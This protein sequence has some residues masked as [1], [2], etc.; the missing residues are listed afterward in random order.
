MNHPL[1][2]AT[3]LRHL[4]RLVPAATLLALAACGGGAGGEN[5]SSAKGYVSVGG[6]V[7]GLS[8]SVVLRNNGGDDL[9][10]SGPGAFAFKLL[11][12]NGSTYAVTVASQPSGQFCTVGNGSGTASSDV[13]TVT[14][15][16]VSDV[17]IGGTVN[18]LTGTVALQ[19]NGANNLAT[20][21]N[22][23]FQ[24]STRIKAGQPYAVTVLTHP[25]NQTC[26]VTN[27]AGT[28]TANVTNVVIDCVTF[29]L[30]PLPTIYGT[31]KAIAYG[32][33]RAGGP[34]AG[35]VPTDAQITEDLLLMERAGFRLIRLFGADAVS[36]KIL[37]I[38]TASNPLLKFQQG[39]YLQGATL[40]TCSDPVNN[41]QIAK[42]IEL[43]RTY[44]NVVTVSVGNETSFANNLPVSCL[45]NYIR[46][47]RSKV[48]QPVTADDDYTFFAGRAANGS[49]PDSIVPLIDFVAIHMYPISNPNGWD[50]KQSGV[51]AGAAR[52]TAMMNAALDYS[53]ASYNAVRDYSYR[54]SSGSSVSIGNTRP[55]VVGETGW[56]AIRTNTASEI[57]GFAARETNAKWYFDLVRGWETGGS[58]P[59]SVFYFSAFDEAWKGNDDGWGLWKADRSARYGLCG[60]AA[61]EPCNAD[62]Y[63]GAGFFGAATPPSGSYSIVDFNTAGVTY[64]LS[65]FGGEQAELVTTGIP[66]GGP[67]GRV[68]RINRAAG[69]QCWAGTTISVGEQ[70]SVGRLPFTANATTVR[71]RIHVPVAGMSVKLKVEDATN[72]GV[73]VETDTTATAAGW[74][75]LLFDFSR[76]TPGTAPLNAANRYNKLSIFPNFSCATG[77]GPSSDEVFFV[78]AIT[79]IGATAA[80]EPPLGSNN[81]GGNSGTYT[82]L[83]FNTAGLAYTLTPFGG[84]SA[85]VQSTNVPAGGPGGKVA[86]LVRP[87]SAECYAG[88]TM[89]VGNQLTIGAIPFSA[90]AKTM[91]VRLYSSVAGASI[92]LKVENA[93]NGG[94]SVETDRVAVAGWQTL[95]FDFGAQSPGTAALNTANVYNKISIFPA[96]SCGGPNPSAESTYHV[97]PITFIGAN[98]PASPPL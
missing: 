58:G 92:K 66:A 12:A 74:Q 97:G 24:F 6:T 86:S 63:A 88:V 26:T 34:G 96:F 38:A 65:P 95:T 50:W 29:A 11:I 36:D 20:A 98:A 17:T 82:V 32:A 45:A 62:L 28:A 56:K 73:S 1:H 13:A 27:G 76:Q 43:A 75:T 49:K 68:A 25:D 35:E 81:G 14:V 70:F 23:S 48:T 9:T 53:K 37:R 3:F 91:T 4:T 2:A 84:L 77:Q 87:V 10:V 16:C 94:I 57:E 79:F 60:S 42:G 52:A 21:S 30:R 18:G 41:A 54:N 71:I 83:D 55:I 78:G 67:A 7:T 85:E 47:V 5:W 64:T 59:K 31:G 80:A 89:S 61:G 46:Q 19:N 33:F 90:T 22:G 39:I 15:S 93:G 40:P 44:S 69:S 72:A 51:A 8:G